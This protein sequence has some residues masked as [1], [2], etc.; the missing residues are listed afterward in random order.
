MSSRKIIAR[1][2]QEKNLG[3]NNFLLIMPPNNNQ[4]ISPKSNE[5]PE[6]NLNVSVASVSRWKFRRSRECLSLPKALKRTGV[7][8]YVKEAVEKFNANKHVKVH[9]RE[10]VSIGLISSVLVGARKT[11]EVVE[12]AEAMGKK[13]EIKSFPH[14]TTLS[15]ILGKNM[16]YVMHHVFKS[17]SRRFLRIANILPVDFGRV[18][19]IDSHGVISKSRIASEGYIKGRVASGVKVHLE[20][21]DGVPFEVM[22]S[23][24]SEHDSQFLEDLLALSGDVDHVVVDRAYIDLEL[25]AELA[26]KGIIFT[27]RSESNLRM[28]VVEGFE[29]GGYMV[30]K[31]VRLVDGVEVRRFEVYNRAEGKVYDVLT[32]LD[33]WKL[34]VEPYD[35][36]WHI[37]VVFQHL[38]NLGF[39]PLGNSHKAFVASVFIY[40]IAYLILLIYGKLARRGMSVTKIREKFR[41]WFMWIYKPPRKPPW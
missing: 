38:T 23:T 15:R 20:T 9:D 37:E 5:L 24:A 3:E 10:D 13:L 34:A 6:D 16:D 39:R 1:N 32:T 25:M 11:E 26:K 12:Y 40:L 17:L 21:V 18:A 22:F 30:V 14:R 27:T 29:D 36:R 7:Y 4:K 2:S 31:S 28:E 41:R 35:F 33:D 19:V 8:R